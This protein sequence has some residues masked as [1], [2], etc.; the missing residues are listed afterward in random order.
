MVGETAK[1]ESDV[2]QM[3]EGPSRLPSLPVTLSQEGCQ[4]KG[5]QLTEGVGWS[6]LGRITYRVWGSGSM[7]GAT[8]VTVIWVGRGGGILGW[9]GRDEHTQQ[10]QARLAPGEGGGCLGCGIVGWGGGGCESVKREGAS[11][12]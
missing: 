7:G 8:A 5:R 10:W 3:Q 4:A 11:S 6:I 9:S 2:E 12:L 1:P